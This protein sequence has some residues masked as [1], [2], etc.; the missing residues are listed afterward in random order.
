MPSLALT[1]YRLLHELM[2][3]DKLT[4]GSH[5]RI[6]HS[7]G[8]RHAMEIGCHAGREKAIFGIRG[9]VLEGT[10]VIFTLENLLLHHCSYHRRLQI[11]RHDRVYDDGLLKSC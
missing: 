9:S 2:C 7:H 10:K 3:I 6:H 4:G 11:H 1:L 5:T 8:N